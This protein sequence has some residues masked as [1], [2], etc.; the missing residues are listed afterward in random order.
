MDL[1]NYPRVSQSVLGL[2]LKL[3][4]SDSALRRLLLNH[5]LSV[6]RLALKLARGRDLDLT[7]LA[8]ASLL[9]DIGISRTHAPG[10]HCHGERPYLCHGVI[11][12]EDCEQAGLPSHGM[13][14]ETH[15]GTGLTVEEIR[16]ANLG[17]PERDMLPR[18]AEEKLICYAD[19][20]FSKSSQEILSLSIVRQRVGRHGESPLQ[21]FETL[22]DEFS[23]S[24]SA[25]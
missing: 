19:Q 2:F 12:R 15:V 10:I 18:T 25:L 7:F 3:Y 23:F 6:G 11:G 9:H 21:R 5:S 24:E 13:V 1:G 17:L 14:C 8:E 4:P 22:H 20:F 16:R